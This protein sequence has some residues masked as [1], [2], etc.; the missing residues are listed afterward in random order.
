MRGKIWF[1]VALFG[2]VIVYFIASGL[3]DTLTDDIPATTQDDFYM[4]DFRLTVYDAAG[5]PEYLASGPD[6]RRDSN[7]T[8]TL[9]APRIAWLGQGDPPWTLTAASAQLDA[10]M[11]HATLTGGVVIERTGSLPSRF[12]TDHAESDLPRREVRTDA[13]V[14]L[15]QGE[16][17]LAGIGLHADLNAGRFTLPQQV[18]GNYVPSR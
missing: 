16:H 3:R 18:R 7:G 14:L 2:L 15:T 8:L 4:R 9:Q 12:T 13:P 10:R 17:T 1:A 11:E 6:L 5:R